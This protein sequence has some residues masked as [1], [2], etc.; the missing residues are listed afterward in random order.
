MVLT[1]RP[2]SLSARASVWLR[3]DCNWVLVC[4]VVAYVAGIASFLSVLL[5]GGSTPTR[6]EFALLVVCLGLYLALAASTNALGGS[7]VGRRGRR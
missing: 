4:Y 6:A 1:V 3:H 5:R 7:G 2:D